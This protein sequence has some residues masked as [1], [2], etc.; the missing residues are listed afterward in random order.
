[1][2]FPLGIQ[3]GS[4]AG[5]IVN[6][7]QASPNGEVTDAIP[8][9]P[10]GL[11]VPVGQTLVLLGGNVALEGGNLT[12]TSGRIELGGVGT[13]LVKLNEIQKGYALDY[14]DVQNFEDIQISQGSIVYGSGEAGGDIQL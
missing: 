12:T 14:T 3:F 2:S 1:V 11:K 7:S 10:I 8:P 9:N 5:R 13:G 4:N 6:Q